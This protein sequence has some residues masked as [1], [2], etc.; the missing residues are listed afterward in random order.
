MGMHQE[1]GGANSIVAI[2]YGTV[3]HKIAAT[4]IG[5]EAKGNNE[6]ATAVGAISNA[7]G[8]NSVSLGYDSSASGE[9][10]IAIGAK[11]GADSDTTSA[12]SKGSIAIGAKTSAMGENAIAIGKGAKISANTLGH[13]MAIGEGAEITGYASYASAIGYGAKAGALNAVALGRDANAYNTDCIAIGYNTRSG[14]DGGHYHIAIGHEAK[15]GK[16]GASNGI[17]IGYGAV[18]QGQNAVAIGYGAVASK[19]HST[20]IGNGAQTEYENEI[21]IGTV[22]DFVRIRGNLIVD[23]NVMLGYDDGN[24]NR[25]KFV[26]IRECPKSL[27]NDSSGHLVGMGYADN[28]RL[29]RSQWSDYSDFVFHPKFRNGAKIY[30]HYSDKRLK[31]IGKKYEAGLAELKK[32]DFYHFTFKS[33]KDKTPYVGVIAQD[34]QKVFPDA[35]TSDIYGYLRIRWDEMFYAVINAVKELDTRIT[36]LAEQVKANIDKTAQL[37]ETVQAQQKTIEE[38]QKQNAEFEKRLARLEKK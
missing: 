2:G 17:A 33:D 38:L 19:N 34:L 36:T 15:A 27:D 26:A 10:S 5:T 7:G 23:G 1:H 3:T 18:S 13:S 9:N 14:V 37:E 35:V 30:V 29:W 22:N 28:S 6:G 20:A 12:P 24:D 4:V 8:K 21:R 25:G 16:T 32:L 11:W 31:D